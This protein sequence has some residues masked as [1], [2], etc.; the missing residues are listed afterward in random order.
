MVILRVPI[1]HE[2]PSNNGKIQLMQPHIH[3]SRSAY[4]SQIYRIYYK[5]SY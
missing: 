5:N 2:Y 4:F 3:H 1:I